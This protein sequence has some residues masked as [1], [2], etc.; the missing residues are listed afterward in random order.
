MQL[1]AYLSLEPSITQYA[2]AYFKTQ[3]HKHSSY[4]N[5]SISQRLSNSLLLGHELDIL[6]KHLKL[7]TWPSQAH[8]ETP[9]KFYKIAFETTTI[10]GLSLA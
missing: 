10:I 5:F 8:I 7:L 2:K 9:K 3:K 6:I 4:N 1:K